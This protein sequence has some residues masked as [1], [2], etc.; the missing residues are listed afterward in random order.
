VAAGISTV[1]FVLLARLVWMQVVEGERYH[2]L[3][4]FNSVSSVPLRAPRGLVLDRNL[5]VM[6][7]NSPSL[8]VGLTPAPLLGRPELAESVFALLASLLEMDAQVIREKFER[9]RTRPFAPVRLATNVDRAL[10]TRLEELRDRLPGVVVLTDSKRHYPQPAAAHALGY[11]SEITDSQLNSLSAK[12]YHL[13]DLVGQTGLER[14]YDEVLKGEDG[15]FF[16][17]VNSLGRQLKEMGQV[18]PLPG[19][20]LVLTLNLKLQ[21]AAEEA[22]RGQSGAVVALDPRNGEILALCSAPDY[23]L[24]QF[25][26]RIK[27]K[28]W[29]ALMEDEQHPFTNRALQG[30]YPP[31]SVFKIVTTSAGLESGVLVP[32][33]AFTCLGIFW[34][35]T[36]P[37]RCWKEVGHGTLTLHRAI[38]ESCDIYFYHVGLKTKVDTLSQF[39]REYG[40]GSVTGVDLPGEASGLVPS[41]AWKERTQHMPWFP[42]NTVM[43]SIGQGYL[44]ATPLQLA[45]MTALV[46]NGGT[47][48]APHLLKRI[49]DQSGR[50]LKEAQP[51]PVRQAKVSAETIRIIQKA[52]TDAVNAPGGTA[53]RARVPG[54]VVAG[55]TGT[56]QNPHGEDHADFVSFAPAE[57]PQLVVAVVVENGGEGGLTAAPIA[58]KIYETYFSK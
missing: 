34:I 22:L 35:S 26:G 21:L 33:T 36:W 4:Y 49:T 3:A 48:Y 9:Q 12:G 20:N 38:V 52:M 45:M 14:V 27:V 6:V 19:N 18:A 51:Q 56:A 5:E 43:M 2:S 16:I 11:V 15:G 7:G 39:A 31:G 37:Y 30:L 42:G 8:T 55:K 40:F 1:F 32:E 29:A 13:G 41:A 50:T 57:N 44:L 17:Q 47:C 58:K 10:V 28:D 46:A 53:W 54:L 23:D 24:N 25:S